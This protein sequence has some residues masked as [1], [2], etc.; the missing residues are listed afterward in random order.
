MT[1][2]LAEALPAVAR[3]LP[4]VRLGEWPTP[5]EPLALRDALWVKREDLSSPLYGGN[6]IRCLEPVFAAIEARGGRRLHATG[7]W[8]SN[9]ALAIAVHGARA[10]FETAATLFPQPPSRAA[11]HNLRALLAT[12]CEAR[13][14]RSLAG[15]PL[16]YLGARIQGEAI[17]APGAAVPRG[18]LGHLTAALE[19]ALDVAA[20]VLPAP[21]H[22]VLAVGSTCTTAGLLVGFATAARIGLWPGPPPTVHAVRVTPWP[23]TAH[24]RIVSLALGAGRLLEQLGGPAAPTRGALAAGLTVSGAE[25]GRGYGHATAGGRAAIAAFDRAGGPHLDTTY[26][27]KSGAWLLGQL[28]AFD[29]PALYWATKSAVLPPQ[30]DAEAAAAAVRPGVARWLARGAAAGVGALDQGSGT[31]L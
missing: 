31:N 23:V 15:F 12:P 10:G 21:R 8:G 28:A 24:R 6:K 17:I 22:V 29:G 1:D 14:L 19:V 5:I 27:G 9:Q 13:L 3:A 16:A 4:R 18:A 30:L 2:A 7:A 26:A 11:A 25:L 20:G